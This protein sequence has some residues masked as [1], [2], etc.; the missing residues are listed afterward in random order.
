V[1][2][3]TEER[4]K[5]RKSEE[6]ISGYRA[7]EMYYAGYLDFMYALRTGDAVFS[8]AGLM[9]IYGSIEEGKYFE[10]SAEYRI[11]RELAGSFMAFRNLVKGEDC[12]DYDISGHFAPFGFTPEEFPG[13]FRKTG[14]DS[15]AAGRY[16]SGVVN[17][18]DSL[19]SYPE[20]LRRITVEYLNTWLSDF[21]SVIG[22][23]YDEIRKDGNLGKLFS[24]IIREPG[25]MSDAMMKMTAV[26]GRHIKEIEEAYKGD[27]EDSFL[28]TAVRYNN[29]SCF[30]RLLSLGT[31]S[32]DSIV[33]YP[34]EDM[35]ILI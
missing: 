16:L 8:G 5:I 21:I 1:S 15:T 31:L 19:S 3:E 25:T 22:P 30:E 35:E 18:L 28:N 20:K 9:F 4:K 6:E 14:D 33:S 13:F 23:Y 17:F 2:E 27:A 34:T 26:F 7:G 11:L 10:D 12:A 24:F 32:T 29:K